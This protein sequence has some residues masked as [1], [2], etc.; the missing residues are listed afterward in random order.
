MKLLA[1]YLF[2]AVG[3]GLGIW[4]GRTSL[5]PRAIVDGRTWNRCSSSIVTREGSSTEILTCY[6]DAKVEVK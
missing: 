5:A 6:R 1:F 2:L 3:I 4:I